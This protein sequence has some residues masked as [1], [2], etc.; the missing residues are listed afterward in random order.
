MNLKQFEVFRAVMHHG[1]VTKAAKTLNVSQPAVSQ[2][3]ASLEAACGF[4][5]FNRARGRAIPTA[6][7]ELLV[8]EIDRTFIGVDRVKR[9]IEGIRSGRWGALSVAVFPAMGARF[10]PRIVSGFCETRPEVNMSIESRRSRSLIDWVAAHQ[11]DFGI[12]LLPAEQ[13]GVR[14][15]QLIS[16]PGVCVLPAGHRLA[17]K[18][19]IHATDLADEPFI[20]LGRED[21]SR[22]GVDKVFDDLGT[23]RDIRIEAEQSESACSF[24]AFGVGVS[25]VDPFS[26]YDYDNREIVVL[27]FEPRVDFNVWLLT[28]TD[29]TLDSLSEEFIGYF[30]TQV[31]A[32]TKRGPQPRSIERQTGAVFER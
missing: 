16:L 14:S 7:A 6:E 2:S 13:P 18:D 3:I 17:G 23:P 11:V 31:Q 8:S 25:V 10:L 28:A 19:S 22:F 20:S 30:R 1:G 12:G 9:V 32:F 15:V 29:R 21:R 24:V 26:A 27:P 4:K 5:L